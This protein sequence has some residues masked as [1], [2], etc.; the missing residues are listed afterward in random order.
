MAG[1][2]GAR[3]DYNYFIRYIGEFNGKFEHRDLETGQLR[4]DDKKMYI[5]ISERRGEI[6]AVDDSDI[7]ISVWPT[8]LVENSEED[9]VHNDSYM[10]FGYKVGSYQY[11]FTTYEEETNEPLYYNEVDFNNKKYVFTPIGILTFDDIQLWYNPF[12]DSNGNTSCN[13]INIADEALAPLMYA[14]LNPDGTAIADMITSS[15]LLTRYRKA[16]FYGTAGTT[17]YKLPQQNL[18]DDEVTAEVLQ[19]DGKYITI[20]ENE[21][22]TVNRATGTVTF[23]NAPGI[24]PSVGRDNVIIKYGIPFVEQES[25]RNFSETNSLQ[26]TSYQLK[27]YPI[28]ESSLKV[29]ATTSNDTFQ[30]FNYTLDN[31]EG[32]ISLDTTTIPDFISVTFNYAADIKMPGEAYLTLRQHNRNT[33]IYGYEQS[34]SVFASGI[35]NTDTFCAPNDITYWPDDN[36]ITLG[37]ESPIL[38]YARNSGYLLTFKEND[39][40]CFVRQGMTINEKIVFPTIAT[41][42]NLF[43]VHKP[44]ELDNEALIATNKGIYAAYYYDGQLKTE[45]RSYFCKDLDNIHR[46]SDYLVKDNMLY[47]MTYTLN[48]DTNRMENIQYVFDLLSKSYV[49]EGSSPTG[50]RYSTSLSFQYEIYKNILPVEYKMTNF[51]PYVDNYHN[52][53]GNDYMCYNNKNVYH[54]N[55]EDDEKT[56][57]IIDSENNEVIDNIKAYYETP[58]L[59]MNA[60]NVAKT[61][62]NLYIN[63]RSKSDA[64]F[65]IGYVNEEGHNE[66]IIKHYGQID[67]VFPKL[68]QLKA[69]IK[70]FMNVKIYIQND[71]NEY[72]LDKRYA[73]MNFNRIL[74]EYQVAGKYRGE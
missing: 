53:I 55:I 29:F 8:P 42:S 48:P 61:I 44:I 37:D 31:E 66:I 71:Q 57:I 45:L 4:I 72:N 54:V 34:M 49:K 47:I 21:G 7:I 32:T 74:I 11:N 9:V 60:I 50:A 25:E 73:D 36:Y 23:T 67:D 70:K 63:T 24:S 3:N 13:V 52:K 41:N 20:K 17:I 30:L 59:D 16:G 56:D 69:K 39:D 62:K 5:K 1:F 38:G 26:T 15:N 64:Y 40:T 19:N 35:N 27:H 2:E 43:A 46:L 28:K 14:S 65:E 6:G 18:S 51:T 22:L 58:F 12:T 68:I 33:T 10:G